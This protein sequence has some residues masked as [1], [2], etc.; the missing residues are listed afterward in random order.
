MLKWL[1]STGQELFLQILTPA[2]GFFTLM[3]WGGL[4]YQRMETKK[5]TTLALATQFEHTNLT[6][7]N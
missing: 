1:F 4:L 2:S 5:I 6:T 3:W 7:L